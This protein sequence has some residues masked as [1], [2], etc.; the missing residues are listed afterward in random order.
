MTM[1]RFYGLVRGERG[2]ASRLGHKGIVSHA[3]GW[4]V[5]VK[6]ECEP[7]VDSGKDVCFVYRT[8]GE[9]D[10]HAEL[11]AEVRE[12]KITFVKKGQR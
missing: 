9:N 6:V 10:S 11:I 8:G 7:D 2:K 12:N 1:A 3:Q 5:G 4:R